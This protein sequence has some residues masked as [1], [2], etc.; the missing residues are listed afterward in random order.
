MLL[1]YLIVFVGGVRF[2]IFI[3]NKPK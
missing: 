3:S 2:G 1:T